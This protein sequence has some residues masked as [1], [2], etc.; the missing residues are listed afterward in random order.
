MKTRSRTTPSAHTTRAAAAER[1]R[2]PGAGGRR[3]GQDGDQLGSSARVVGQRARLEGAFGFDVEPSKAPSSPARSVVQRFP[4]TVATAPIN[5]TAAPFAVAPLGGGTVSA[6][7]KLT[8]P[9]P[10]P[11]GDVGT[12]IVK[13]LQVEETDEVRFG[14]E[15]LRQMGFATPADRLIM[16]GT[17][18]FL[19]LAGA[20]GFAP[21]ATGHFV[22]GTKRIGALLVMQDLGATGASTIVSKVMSAAT[23]ADIDDVFATMIDP[24]VLQTVARAMVCDTAI[25]NFDRIT[26]DG[27]NFGNLMIRRGGGAATQVFLIDT[28]ARLPPIRDEIVANAASQGALYDARVFPT[29]LLK[30]LFDDR[31]DAVTRWIEAIPFVIAAQQNEREEEGGQRNAFLDQEQPYIAQKVAQAQLVAQPVFTLAINQEIANLVAMMANKANP[32]RAAIKAAAAASPGQSFK[33]LKAQ[34]GYLDQRSRAPGAAVGPAP[35]PPGDIGHAG[36]ASIVETYGRYRLAKGVAGVPA[37][38]AGAPMAHAAV[39]VP[40]SL[41]VSAAMQVLKGKGLKRTQ[42]ADFDAFNPLYV[43]FRADIDHHIQHLEALVPIVDNLIKLHASMAEPGSTRN[44]RAMASLAKRQ[45]QLTRL[46]GP[47]RAAVATAIQ[48]AGQYLAKADQLLA[49]LPHVSDRYDV[50]RGTRAPLQ[51]QRNSLAAAAARL[52]QLRPNL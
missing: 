28:N 16:P 46:R 15:F 35:A 11:P 47:L 7:F 51:V 10:L 23:R 32:N 33:T 19:Q 26:M 5:W 39:V 48:W 50:L 20:L 41:R 12:V 31:N 37:N 22:N 17:A 27:A 1:T 3:P 21:D 8:Q 9:P 2:G 34:V 24:V 6:I 49:E 45:A 44:Q 30:G 40:E 14:E 4:A 38:A 13:V 52:G 18:E 43:Q 36:A 29:R 42:A 25:G